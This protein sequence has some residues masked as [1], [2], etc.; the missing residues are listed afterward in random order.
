MTWY[1]AVHPSQFQAEEELSEGAVGVIERLSEEVAGGREDRGDGGEDI[2][3]ECLRE[4][5]S[6][7][8]RPI[9]DAFDWL[10][11]AEWSDGIDRERVRRLTVAFEWSIGE[12]HPPPGMRGPSGK[13]GCEEI[14]GKLMGCRWGGP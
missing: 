7:N 5:C 14:M 4:E 9:F 6:G 3:G 12:V 11:D 10:A 2:R 13:D 8:R 1:G